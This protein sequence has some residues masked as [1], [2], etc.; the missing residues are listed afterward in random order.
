VLPATSASSFAGTGP[1][2]VSSQRN[3]QNWAIAGL[4]PRV[5]N[6]SS[7]TLSNND[8]FIIHIQ[9]AMNM[10][11]SH[12][13][14]VLARLCS[15]RPTPYRRFGTLLLATAIAAG[16]ATALA[17]IPRATATNEPYSCSSCREVN[18]PDNWVLDA[19]TDNYTR[20]DAIA[21]LWKKEG[22]GYKEVKNGVGGFHAEACY[23]PY[24]SNEFVGH[25][26]A[27]DSLAPAHQAGRETNLTNCQY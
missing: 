9:G 3:R 21:R 23:S 12:R 1:V 4:P 16:C 15:I 13:H 17:P 18:G 22:I 20:E 11:H 7:E 14:S 10:P 8:L 5:R 25:G 19:E 24:K 2:G 26:E 27:L 6:G